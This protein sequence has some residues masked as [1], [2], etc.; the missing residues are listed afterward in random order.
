VY[1]MANTTVSILRGT[2]EDTYGDNE[3]SGTVIASGILAFIS[4]PGM[5]PLRPQIL[6]TTV[7]GPAA[8]MPS[9]VREL[10]CI[11]PSGT[12]VTNDDQI[13]DENSGVTYAVYLTAQLGRLGGLV[14]DLQVMLRQVTTN[15]PV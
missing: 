1:A 9:V 15:Q 5:S 6:G 11:L 2:V 8:Q 14:P 13:L 3:D 10:I 12:D 4:S 7:Y